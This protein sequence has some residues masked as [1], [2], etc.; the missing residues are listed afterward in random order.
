MVYTKDLKLAHQRLKARRIICT[1]AAWALAHRDLSHSWFDETVVRWSLGN[2]F[3]SCFPGK[4]AEKKQVKPAIGA[5][6]GRLTLDQGPVSL[7]A[8]NPVPTDMTSGQRLSSN[9]AC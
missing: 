1:C 6:P 4:C 9:F 7:Q 8:L 5:V 3:F 2:C